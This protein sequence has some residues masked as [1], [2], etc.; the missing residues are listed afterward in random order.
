VSY[1]VQ[2]K[3]SVRYE[4]KLLYRVGGNEN[5]SINYKVLS[6]H[7]YEEQLKALLK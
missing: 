1:Q 6:V 2:V 5:A 7:F 3:E 4:K